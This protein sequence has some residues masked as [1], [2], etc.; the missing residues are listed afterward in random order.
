M[1]EGEMGDQHIKVIDKELDR[2]ILVVCSKFEDVLWGDFPGGPTFMKRISGRKG[3]TDEEK[4]AK[5]LAD[6]EAGKLSDP[7]KKFLEAQ[8][9][10]EQEETL[11][12]HPYP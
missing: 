10:K 4:Y 12:H 6:A 8:I 2:Q 7:E 9:A 5:K 3:M 11:N 1:I